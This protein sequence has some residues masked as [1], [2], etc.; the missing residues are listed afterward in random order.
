VREVLDRMYA[1]DGRFVIVSGNSGT[2]KSSLVDAGLL[3]QLEKTGLPGGRRCL[4]VRV[5][6]SQGE[7]PFDALKGVLQ[8]FV[9]SAGLPP[10]Y[11]GEELYKKPE[12]LSDRSR[13]IISKGTDRNAMVLFLDQMEELFTVRGEKQTKEQSDTFLSA[14]YRASREID[15]WVIATIRSDFLHHCHHHQDMLSVLNGH[16]H[17]ALGRVEPYMMHDMIMKPAQCAELKI[18]KKLVKAGL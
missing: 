7:H 5:V 9:V 12:S 14:L 17:Y 3:P 15:L 10:E 2:G 8:Y 4:C 1:P 16:G 11:L 18:P 6:P 13:T